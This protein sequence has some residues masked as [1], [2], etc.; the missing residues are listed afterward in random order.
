MHFTVYDVFYSLNSHHNVSAAI[1][2]TFRVMLILQDYK[3]TNVVS[4][5]AVTP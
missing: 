4:C 2:A 1:M 5:F 3:G